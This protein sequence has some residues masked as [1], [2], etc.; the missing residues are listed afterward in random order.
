[1]RFLGVCW[2]LSSLVVAGLLVSCRTDEPAPP[3]Q[4]YA[5]NLGDLLRFWKRNERCNSN[6]LPPPAIF[7]STVHD[8]AG[9]P[10][11]D[12]ELRLAARPLGLRHQVVRLSNP[13]GLRGRPLGTS[14]IYQRH[15]VAL[16][17]PGSFACFR[18]ADFSRNK[19]LEAALNTAAF[20]RHWVLNQQLIGWRQGQAHCF[21]SLQRQWQPY[22]GPLPFGK[23][24]K[25]FED[26]QF[27]CATDCQGEFGGHV[28]F[29]DKRTGLTHHTTATCATTVW[30]R[31]GKYHILASLLSDAK[32]GVVEAPEKL[33]LVSESL[34]Q[35]QSW[36]YSDLAGLVSDPLVKRTF[37][38]WIAM[39]GC[40]QWHQQTL[41]LVTW[42]EATFLATINQ[43]TI[44]AVD[45][46][47]I[48]ATAAHNSIAVNYAPDL[49]L[50]SL[51]HYEKG[52]SE[53]ASCLVVQG[54]LL[55]KIEWGTQPKQY[56][57]CN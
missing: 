39:P 25:L 16:Y 4:P 53:E 7:R 35:A 20:E 24:P 54:S 11:L 26:E 18:L 3:T 14:V 42:R 19:R 13:S 50:L 1:M 2:L 46:L 22:A 32:S 40:F 33:P 9:R 8:S 49:T 38:H 17:A 55:T 15:L 27:I 52:N 29:F 21:D 5:A 12:F 41:Y 56:S 6:L 34:N 23:G 30:K 37:Y 28:Y 47:F 31:H 44:T 45:P 48:E 57:Y 10:Q 36:E 43:R 51:P